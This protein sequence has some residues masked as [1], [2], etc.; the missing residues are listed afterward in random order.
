MLPLP[1]W[2]GALK[3]DSTRRRRPRIEVV[4]APEE[5]EDC[6]A[7]FCLSP[8]PLATEQLTLEGGEEAIAQRVVEAVADRPH[9]RPH[10]RQVHRGTRG[11]CTATWIALGEAKC[12]A[13]SW[14]TRPQTPAADHSSQQQG[15]IW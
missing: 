3:L 8:E 14:H 7:S 9:R 2:G 6:Q 10:A 12:V 4:P 15:Q 13:H 1:A 11:P 5:I